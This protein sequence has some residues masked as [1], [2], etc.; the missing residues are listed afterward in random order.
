M[1]PMS[2]PECQGTVMVHRGD[3]VTC[4]RDVCRMDLPLER[5]FSFHTSFAVCRAHSCPHCVVNVPVYPEDEECNP[6]LTSCRTRRR[7][8]LHVA[9]TALA[10]RRWHAG[11]IDL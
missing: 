10:S 9:R 3:S 6:A 5:W 7:G 2:M 8:R 1:R 11:R 4:T